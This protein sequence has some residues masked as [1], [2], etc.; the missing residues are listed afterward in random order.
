MGVSR[1]SKPRLLHTG[2]VDR[3]IPA[4]FA[5]NQAQYWLQARLGE[6]VPNRNA[7]FDA[8]AGKA[9]ALRRGRLRHVHIIRECS[10]TVC[11]S[12]FDQRA[13]CFGVVRGLEERLALLIVS[14]DARHTGQS[15]QMF[16]R[17]GSRPDDSDQK[18]HG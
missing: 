14:K 6:Q 12:G 8:H 11:T 5:G 9:T 7:A 2:M 16:L 4:L 3:A 17:H 1:Q 10:V 13:I 15:G 18:P